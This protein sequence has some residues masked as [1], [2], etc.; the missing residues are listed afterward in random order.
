VLTVEETLPIVASSPPARR[1]T[2]KENDGAEI[3]DRGLADDL[4]V[5]R[6]LLPPDQPTRHKQTTTAQHVRSPRPLGGLIH[7]YK[8][9]RLTCEPYGQSD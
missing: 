8:R 7:E 6:D 3:S 1:E 5:R 4:N 9:R 2:T